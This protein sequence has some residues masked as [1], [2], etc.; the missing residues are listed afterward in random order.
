[1]T[2]AET[3]NMKTLW[4]S[5]FAKVNINNIRVLT[6][7]ISQQ[8]PQRIWYPLDRNGTQ[9][10][11]DCWNYVNETISDYTDGDLHF[12]FR[13]PMLN[14]VA[15]QE[16]TDSNLAPIII[17]AII[18]S[19]WSPGANGFAA[20]VAAVLECARVLHSYNLT[21]DVYFVFTNTIS[22]GYSFTY[23]SGNQ[24]MAYLLNE[25]QSE[26]RS[27]AGVMWF[28]RLLYYTY[29]TFGQ[30]I[31]VSYD[32]LM[33]PYDPLRYVLSMAEDISQM[34]GT[35]QTVIS[36]RTY[37]DNWVPTGA[38][39]AWQRGI[40]SISIGQFYNDYV[41]TT[42]YD[43]WNYGQYQYDNA[44]EAVGLV[45]SLVT[46]LGRLGTGVAPSYTTTKSVGVSSTYEMD[47]HLTGLSYV[48]VSVT[49]DKNFS[50]AT[51][52]L[53]PSNDLVYFRN[54]S[55]KTIQMDYLVDER[56]EYTL[57]VT[58]SGNESTNIVISYSQYQDLDWDGLDD[59]EEYMF[60][61]DSLSSD[62]DSDYLPD[63]DEQT[64]GTNPRLPDSDFDGALDG[65]EVFLGCDPLVQDTD[66]DTLFD[67]FEIGLGL[68]PNLADSDQDGLND[69]VELD[70]G[71]DP[72]TADSDSDG[73]S[74]FTEYV[75]LDTNPLSPDSDGDGLSD[76]FEVLNALN[77]LSTDTDMDGL[78][79]SYEVEHCLM[80]FDADTDRDG[81][82]DGQD[83]AP[84]EHW[85]NTVPFI[86]LG[87]F[88]IIII[89]ILV[90]KRRAYM[91]G[92]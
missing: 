47:L 45:C 36:N 87:I 69:N 12:K 17:S 41:W 35:G 5:V 55:D 10:L 37:D 29:D 26:G 31:R 91:R 65:I 71:T 56:G 85:I 50:V 62:T 11:R 59:Y 76:L 74:D 46:T 7:V 77:P 18:S 52:I 19:R 82:P 4:D 51:N 78:S 61:T 86:G 20:S 1:M 54:E 66:S 58:N 90:M 3:F 33:F 22:Y 40:P 68:N 48:N 73:L 8:Y 92:N 2:P 72:L 13:T 53:D 23:S 67:G 80:P 89:G 75:E 30:D 24:G 38:Y 84:T 6:Q 39:E 81:I 15:I 79:D 34:S 14:L 60:G 43:T 9:T 42:E 27:P 64:L 57:R 32:Y 83:W 25:L 28:S 70:L 88:T 49:W 63:A 16:G 44:E 21:N